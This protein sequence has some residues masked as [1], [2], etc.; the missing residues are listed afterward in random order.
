MQPPVVYLEDAKWLHRPILRVRFPMSPMFLSVFLAVTLVSARQ[1]I[2]PI[3]D[4]SA[5]VAVPEPSAQAMAYYRGGNVIWIVR[6]VLAL[7]VPAIV[8]FTGLS[9]RMRNLAQ[10][11]GCRWLLVIA[12]YFALYWLVNGLLHLPLS[13]Y[14]GF[15]RQHAYGLS[16]QSFLRWLRDWLLDWGVMLVFGV[17]VIWFPYWLM[18]RSPW[19]WW[20][21]TA[22]AALPVMFFVMFVEPIWIAPLYNNFGPMHD[23]KLEAEILDLAGWAGIDGGRVFEV[24]MSADTKAVNAYVTGFAGTQADRALGY[25]PAKARRPAGPRSHGARDGPLR[26]G[27]R[28]ARAAGRI[29]RRARGDFS[30]STTAPV[31]CYA[32]YGRRFGIAQLFRHCLLAAADAAIAGDRPG[33]DARRP[34]L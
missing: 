8:L 16:N 5:P 26:A 10:R 33:D 11:V 7:A 18:R 19:R 22:L 31:R 21:Y 29:R 30:W 34:G 1:D 12:V 6:A 32:A 9:I 17:L 25:A 4:S 28:R 14:S 2:P 24:D 27:P 13:Y 20:L 15:V 3:N 23:K